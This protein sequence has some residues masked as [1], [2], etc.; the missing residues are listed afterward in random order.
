MLLFWDS[1]TARELENKC[2][3]LFAKE[4]RIAEFR[5]FRSRSSFMDC[6]LEFLWLSFP[7]VNIGRG[8]ERILDR[9]LDTD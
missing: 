5:C 2:M 9:S 3:L 1:F 7:I 6:P 8:V 4:S